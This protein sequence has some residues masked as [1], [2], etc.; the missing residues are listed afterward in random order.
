MWVN[1]EIWDDVAKANVRNIVGGKPLH[2]MGYLTLD[3]WVD[4]NSGEDRKAYKVRVMKIFLEHEFK[5]MLQIMGADNVIKATPVATTNEVV[6]KSYASGPS[7]GMM[8]SNRSNNRQFNQSISPMPMT[9][10]RQD[11]KFTNLSSAAPAF[12]TSVSPDNEEE[13]MPRIPF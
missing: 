11:N 9:T 1:C 3:K 7:M 5:S 8:G 6:S 13:S 10:N 4:K 12:A 2:G